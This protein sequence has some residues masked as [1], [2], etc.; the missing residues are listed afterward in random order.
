M[1]DDNWSAKTYS[2]Q[3]QAKLCSKHSAKWRPNIDEVVIFGDHTSK[4]LARSLALPLSLTH[5]TS[6]QRNVNA[7]QLNQSF[8]QIIHLFTN[9]LI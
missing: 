9:R 4:S 1:A 6:I 3:F 5:L 8:N 7:T 2:I